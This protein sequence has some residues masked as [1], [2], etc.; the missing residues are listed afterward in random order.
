MRQWTLLA[1]ALVALIAGNRAALAAEE[2]SPPRKTEAA[3]DSA[4]TERLKEIRLIEIKYLRSN[5]EKAFQAGREK[6]LAI[7]DPAAVK[8][9][10]HVLYGENARYRGLL[11][12]ALTAQANRGSKLARAYLQEIAVGDSSAANRHRAVGNLKGLS[13]DPATDRLMAHLA[14]DKVPVIRDRAATALATLD[15]KRAIWLMVEQLVTEETRVTGAE[16]R[17]AQIGLD[18]RAQQCDTPT[19]RTYQVQAAVP[20]GVATYTIQLPQVNMVDVATTIA[21]TDRAVQPTVQRVQI[22]HPEIL[23]ALKALTGRDFGYNLAAWQR[24]LQSPEAVNLVPAWQPA[25]TPAEK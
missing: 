6:L 24:W 3:G 25:V 18:I 9:M 17:D 1:A 10:V 2:A 21:M 5:D 16:V 13:G 15:E 11:L 12:E 7:E 23:A 20:G 22:Q 8:P 19:F 4:Y 14:Q